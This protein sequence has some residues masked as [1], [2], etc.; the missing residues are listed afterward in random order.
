MKTFCNLTS[1]QIRKNTLTIR[2]EFLAGRQLFGIVIP[3][4]NFLTGGLRPNR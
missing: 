2:R 1:S 4:V 3:K